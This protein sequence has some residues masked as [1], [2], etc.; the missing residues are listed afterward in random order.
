MED[1]LYFNFKFHL[2]KP[3]HPVKY[4]VVVNFYCEIL[5]TGKIFTEESDEF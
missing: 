5:S 4:F 3:N 1:C 2:K